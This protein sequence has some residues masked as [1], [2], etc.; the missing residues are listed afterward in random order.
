MYFKC[1]SYNQIIEAYNVF[2]IL[3]IL[4]ENRIKT[5][6]FCSERIQRVAQIFENKLSKPNHMKTSR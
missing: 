6:S 2:V 4:Q 1:F 3:T 5:Q